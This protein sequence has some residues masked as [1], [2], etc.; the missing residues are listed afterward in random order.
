M[1]PFAMK[2]LFAYLNSV[3]R[4]IANKHVVLFLDYDGTLI[5]IVETPNRARIPKQVKQ[6]LKALSASRRC[7]LSVISGR[8][9]KD[10]KKKVG[11]RGI[12]YS[13]NHGLEIQG[14]NIRFEAPVASGYRTILQKIKRELRQRLSHIKGILL[15]D[16]GL[17]LA[18]HYRLTDNKEVPFVGEIFYEVAL[19]Y[20]RS[21]KIKTKIGKKVFEVMPATEWGKG[22]AALWLLSKQ[23]SH[24][25]DKPILPMYVGDDVTDEDAFKALKK[26]ALT[27]FVGNPKKSHAKYYLKNAKEATKFLKWLNALTILWV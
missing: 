3:R 9:L 19:P 23:K 2:Y 20:L 6:L 18:L 24:L 16:K 1:Q 26:K 14:P 25:R 4:Q 10:I 5:P 8:G 17:C 13:G 27:I 21:G 11:L 12:I 15:E 7:T 22:Q